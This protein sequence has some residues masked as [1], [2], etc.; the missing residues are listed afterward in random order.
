MN[1]DFPKVSWLSYTNVYEVNIRQYTTEGTFNAFSLHLNRL[2]DMGVDVLWFMPITPI[3]YKNRKGSLGSYYACS[4]YT[5]IN[6]EFGTSSDFRNIIEKAH[7]LGMK[8]IIDWVANHTGCDHHW[9]ID[10]PSFYKLDSNGNFYDSHG[11]DDVIDLDYSN[12]EMRRKMILSMQYWID[13]FNIDGFRCDMA[14]L[15]PVDFWMQA[16]LAIDAQNPHFWLA[17]L[18][19]ADNIEYMEVFDSAYTWRWM[20][21]ALSFKQTGARDIGSL[22]SLLLDYS[23]LLPNSVLPAWFTSNHDE[24]SW[25]GTEYEKY[26]EMAKPLAVFS[27]MWRGIP[28]VYSGQELPNYKRLLFFD[29]DE[30]IWSSIISMHDFYKLLLTFWKCTSPSISSDV[31]SIAYF[32]S[33]SVE[34]HVL[35]FVR[36]F[37]SLQVLVII[38]FSEYDLNDVKIEVSNDVG[39]YRELF[40]EISIGFSEKFHHFSLR[41]WGYQVW[42]K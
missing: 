38:N 10:H 28:L 19:P 32:T 5:A 1:N 21:A 2:H 14:M 29:K 12:Y 18:D 35:S 20:N 31:N 6:P 25:N 42:Y 22:K 39:T 36:K 27:S 4:S 33:N 11:W 41:A 26:A 17:E 8:V 23:N 13:E 9:T 3:S 16:R 34:H 37:G 7:G 24:N 15:T 30:I 40:T